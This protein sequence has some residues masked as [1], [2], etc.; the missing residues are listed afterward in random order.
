MHAS[1]RRRVLC[2]AL[3]VL[4][5]VAVIGLRLVAL[6]VHRHDEL[7]A[8]ADAQH[9]KRVEV[10]P[11]RG[12]ILDRNGHELA[13][14]LRTESLFAHPWRVSDARAVAEALSGTLDLSRGEIASRL[15][16]DKQFVWLDRFL[17]P[18]RA[19]DVRALPAIDAEGPAIGFLPSS[20]RHYPHGDLAAHV[21]GFASIDGEG[22]A[23]IE[24]RFD[25]ELRGEPTVY[26]VVRDAKAGSLRKM[27]APAGRP[28]R[29]VVLTV[30]VVLQ[31]FVE[32][33]LER[34]VAETGAR[35][36]SAVLIDPATGDVLALAN[37]P[38][39]VLAR[40]GASDERVRVNRSVGHQFEPGSTFKVV[41]MATALDQGAVR[42]EQ[43]FDCENG[44]MALGRRRIRDSKPHGALSAREILQESS[45]IGM[46]KIG[47]R[48]APESFHDAI[49]RFGFGRPTGIELPGELP[50]SFRAARQWNEHSRASIAFGHEIAVTVLQ[51]ASAIATIANDGVRVPPRVVLGLRDEDGVVEPLARPS[52][53]RVVGART[54][55]EIAFMMEGV[56]TEG[57]G[58]R[59]AIPGYRVAGKTGTAQ[60]L[61]GGTYTDD[62][63]VA[64]FGGFAPVSD[65]RV[66]LLV[67]L[68]AP[69]IGRHQGGAVAAPVFSAIL[70]E[71]L[72]HLRVPTDRE[73]EPLPRPPA[74][75]LP[76]ALATPARSRSVIPGV[77]PDVVGLSLREAIVSLRAA[78]CRTAYAGSGR[79]AAQ[80]P[81][82]GTPLAPGGAC[83]ISLGEPAAP[84]A[85]AEGAG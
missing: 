83:R 54:A 12:A 57:T 50:G 9:L 36:G 24:Q 72:V 58:S 45:N 48:L 81:L 11:M 62:A 10:P 63:Y 84:D 5:V 16:S 31:H 40:Y 29:D 43:H 19:S 8:R 69:R 51:M 49:V 53:E 30:D 23:G 78:G 67:V 39:P 41:A 14:S 75:A 38:A 1:D 70:A 46:V 77:A 44:V 65:P 59:A 47:R 33:E 35:A 26:H 42:P 22:L 82:P 34:A 18:E 60:K 85:P 20:K 37:R 7:R 55:R 80:L 25:R 3:G 71:A 27:L 21:I 28:A 73:L 66:A 56:V 2:L 13:M 4:A 61:D 6:Q 52:P 64:S 15:R 32:R 76:V 74:A 68:D 79:V 17:D